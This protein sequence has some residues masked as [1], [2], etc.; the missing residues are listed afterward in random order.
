MIGADCICGC[1]E[2]RRE[3]SQYATDAC[4]ARVYRVKHPLLEDVLPEASPEA[5][6]AA[7]DEFVRRSTL[8]LGDLEQFAARVKRKRRSTT[9]PRRHACDISP[10]AASQLDRLAESW[11]LTKRDYLEM[12]LGE[13]WRKEELFKHALMECGEFLEEEWGALDEAA[14]PY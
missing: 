14:N 4:R 12:V 2:A 5:A 9:K 10:E 11:G 1:G 6:R 7:W 3:R 8:T 13:E